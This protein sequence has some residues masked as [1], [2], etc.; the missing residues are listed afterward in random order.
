V[1]SRIVLIVFL[2]YLAGFLYFLFLSLFQF[3]VREVLS[4]YYWGWVFNNSLVNVIDYAIPLQCTA[5]LL[6]FSVFIHD[7]DLRVGAGRSA[8]FPSLVRVPIV[9]LLFLTLVY[10]F[11]REWIMPQKVLQ[12]DTYTYNTAFSRELLET[13]TAA[14][15]DGKYQ[16]ALTRSTQYRAINPLDDRGDELFRSAR[17][18]LLSEPGPESGSR[19]ADSVPPVT[20][21]PDGLSGP[22]L[23][24]RGNTYFTNEDYFSSYYYATLA[25]QSD[26]GLPDAR[27]LQSRS[28]DK[29]QQVDLSKLQKE[30]AS[31]FE[32]KRKGFLDLESDKSID[33]YYTF[34]ALSQK[35]PQDPDVK[36]YLAAAKEA[37]R[38]ISFFTDEV[39]GI[40]SLPGVQQVL[41]LNGRTD[42]Y[43]EFLYLGKLVTVPQGIYAMDVELFRISPDGKVLLHLKAPY[44]K[45]IGKHLVLRAI[46]REDA[47]NRIEPTV[48]AG[49]IPK[50]TGPVFRLAV[51]PSDL[52]MIAAGSGHLASVG[53]VP[54]WTS[55]KM[56][57]SYGYSPEP[58]YL[59]ILLRLLMPFSFVVLSLFATS[60]GWRLRSRYLTRP[61][62]LALLL[63]PVVPFVINYAVRLYTY[64][65]RLILGFLQLYTGF[66][67]TLVVL[68]A[69]QAV[70]LGLALLT[71]AAQSTE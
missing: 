48:Y 25:L 21:A 60:L 6:G 39:T 66:T 2:T 50:D 49:A 4:I 36:R 52:D 33:A 13:A 55:V 16:I 30:Q 59:E 20:G 54:L 61:P 26:A 41:F 70:L 35:V 28:L 42:K 71:L 37:V 10:A 14:L 44:G 45:V 57:R 29:I 43:T 67:V 15:K 62:L 51:P 69:T 58:I 11:S 53:L 64:G 3:P 56:L 31:I 23:L 18:R 8:S 12:L 7:M 65:F 63:I 24:A 46:D 68:V 40:A 9:L 34:L 38:R 22:E 27:R 5:L 47:D 17:A 1:S 32:Q 19:K